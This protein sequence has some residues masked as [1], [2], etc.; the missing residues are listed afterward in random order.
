M[1][2]PGNASTQTYTYTLDGTAPSST[3]SAPTYATSSPISVTWAATDTQSGVYSTTL[4]YKKEITGSWQ[5]YQTT[6]G[7]SGIIELCAVTRRWPVPL[8][9]RRSR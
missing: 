3:A 5:S 2:D 1:T 4:W 6:T 8:C 9:Y 7:N